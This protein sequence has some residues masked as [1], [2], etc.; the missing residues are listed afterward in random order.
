MVEH[1]LNMQKALDLIPSTL[2]KLS[3]NKQI[4]APSQVA[5]CPLLFLLGSPTS[6]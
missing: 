3:E 4:N 5:F 6:L 2:R 1:L